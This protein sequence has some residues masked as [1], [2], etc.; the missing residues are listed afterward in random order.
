MNDQPSSPERLAQAAHVLPPG[1]S[2]WPAGHRLGGFEFR[3]VVAVRSTSIVYRGW[4]HG[5]EVAVALKEY[6]PAALA[7]RGPYGEVGPAE[8]SMAEAFEHGL[9]AFIDEGRRLARCDHPSIARVLHLLPAHGGACLVMPWYAG[10]PL[11]E[12]RREMSGPPDEPAL[13]ALLDAL[14]AALHEWHRVNGVHGG[15]HPAGVLLLDD[16]RPLLLGPGY[17]ER[18]IARG[19]PAMAALEPGFAA[20]ELDDDPARIGAWSDV[21]ALAQLAR[22]AITSMLPPPAGSTPEPLAAVVERLFFDHPS[23]RYGTAL[24]ATLDA[25]VSPDIGARPQSIVEFAAWLANGPPRRS[26]GSARA[27]PSIDVELDL[28]GPQ[29][30]P[31]APQPA[32][33][34]AR[35]GPRGRLG[36][37][38]SAG[39]PAPDWSRWPDAPSPPAPVK[40]EPAPL[41][42]SAAS[43]PERAAASR[44]SAGT[45]RDP[46]LMPFHQA[47]AADS[48]PRPMA[49]EEEADAATVDLIQRVIDTIPPAPPRREP[50]ARE[51]APP[52]AASAAAPAR[53]VPLEPPPQDSVMRW[54][55]GA[56]T[57][58]AAL[59]LGLW[60]HETHTPEPRPAPVAAEPPAATAP[61]LSPTAPVERPTAPALAETTPAAPVDTSPPP[62]TT[63]PREEFLDPPPQRGAAGPASPR[64]VCG[65]RSGFAL[66]RCFQQQCE[67]SAWARH[68]Q[69]AEF[70]ATDRVPG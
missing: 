56:L 31:P 2:A 7:R 37:G 32:P 59:G 25:A 39:G 19:G 9:R 1:V 34:P 16:D 26:G 61:A 68:P 8:P 63:A 54:M 47:P 55:L 67:R 51:P 18:A 15:V 43:T 28:P 62:T 66:Y 35:P 20:P 57:L 58:A 30:E 24:L 14:L 27:E 3:G 4:D 23:A 49:A 46:P 38:A 29:P 40:A 50:P 65:E 13:R 5:L 10:R 36:R 64:A 22:F 42:S 48:A 69:C 44:L 21:F 17:A 45:R 52:A 53:A 41:P 11:A 33:A 70:R 60:W 12:L 6:L